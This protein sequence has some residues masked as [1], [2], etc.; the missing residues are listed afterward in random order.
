MNGLL[1]NTKMT[2]RCM[3][4]VNVALNT[5]ADKVSGLMTELG[6]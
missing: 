6:A 4:D 2:V 3:Q 1:L 5:I